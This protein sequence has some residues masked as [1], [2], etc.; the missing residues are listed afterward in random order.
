MGL[1]V[2]WNQPRDGLI[3]VWNSDF[4]GLRPV[5]LQGAST[6]LTT[7]LSWQSPTSVSTVL[8]AAPTSN[9]VKH[10]VSCPSRCARLSDPSCELHHVSRWLGSFLA[11][12]KLQRT[13]ASIGLLHS[14][15]DLYVSVFGALLGA[16]TLPSNTDR[17]GKSSP[18]LKFYP[19]VKYRACLTFLQAFSIVQVEY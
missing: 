1:K 2:E 11:N 16:R 3:V 19:F 7:V 6:S 8:V 14:S 17:H 13:V 12:T 4:N 18:V 10:G 5:L 15:G 9:C